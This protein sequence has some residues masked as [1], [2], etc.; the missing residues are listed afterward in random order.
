MSFVKG[1]SIA[2]CGKFLKQDLFFK[3]MTL[4]IGFEF[5]ESY[6]DCR[7]SLCDKPS[8]RWSRRLLVFASQIAVLNS[9]NVGELLLQEYLQD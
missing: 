7:L 8:A 1:S 5:V 4:L 2:G 6:D 3:L 9:S